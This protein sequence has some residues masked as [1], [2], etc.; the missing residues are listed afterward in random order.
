VLPF[1]P[2]VEWRGGTGGCSSGAGCALTRR[3]PCRTSGP[4]H[5]VWLVAYAVG[6][7][8]LGMLLWYCGLGLVVSR[9]PATA[10]REV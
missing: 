4:T 1:L 6:P 8:P 9:R 2:A 7:D 10:T 5:L 3:A